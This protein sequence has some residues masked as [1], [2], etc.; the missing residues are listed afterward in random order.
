MSSNKNSLEALSRDIRLKI[1]DIVYKAGG[2]HIGGCF[3]VTDILVTLYHR[4]LKHEPSKPDWE[5][6]DFLIFSKGHCCLALYTVLNQCN[7]FS[8]R[9]LKEYSQNGSNLGGHPKKGDA[10]GIEAT[11]GSLGHGLAIA[12]GIALS[13]KIKNKD[14]KVFTVMSDGEMNEGSVWE[15][16]M[17][18]SQQKLDNLTLIVDNNNQI[19]LDKLSNILSVEPLDQRFKSF[20]WS[21]SRV[22]GHS[23]NAI[24]NA[25]KKTPKEIEKPLVVIA[26]TIKGKGVSFMEGV[27][28]WHYRGPTDQEYRMAKEEINK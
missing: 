25:L 23:H 27:T 4:I 14:N 22:D 24:L 8:D 10:P 9:L 18:A 11:T 26:D 6:R 15:S 20:G 7:Y 2:G 1:L 12:N 28:K 16:I 19:S 5:D 17:F 21:V 13:A 3:S